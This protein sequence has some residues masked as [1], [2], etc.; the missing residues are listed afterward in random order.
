MQIHPC[1]FCG[2]PDPAVA[3][4]DAGVYAMEC[5]GC[6]CRGPVEV[7]AEGTSKQ[8]AGL[9]IKAWNARALEAA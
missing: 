2:H 4:I 5:D 8:S 9:A 7:G 1:P 3:E 6:G